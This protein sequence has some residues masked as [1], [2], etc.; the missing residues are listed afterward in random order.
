MLT[1]SDHLAEDRLLWEFWLNHGTDAVALRAR[2]EELPADA[3]GAYLVG[4]A[5]YGG[6]EGALA[7]LLERE[8][9]RLPAG[10]RLPEEVGFFLEG[11]PAA[12]PASPEGRFLVLLAQ[13]PAPGTARFEE[14]KTAA[15]R[16]SSWRGFARAACRANLIPAVA[17]A[18]AQPP[19]AEAVPAAER[20]ALA[21]AA[22]GIEARNRRMLARLASLLEAFAEAGLSPVLLKETAL[23]LDVYPG[24][25][26]RMI[27]DMD[28]LFSASEIDRAEEILL[29]R[30]YRSF[31]GIWSRAW[32]REHHHHIAPL[33]SSEEGI[34]IEPHL[35]IWIPR[36]SSKSIIP[37]MIAAAK[38]HPR[39]RAL[40]PAP[41]H[42]LF[43]LLV[44]IHGNV[45]IGKLGQLADIVALLAA[46][47]PGIDTTR[48][49]DFARRTGALPFVRDSLALLSKACGP[50]YLSE[51]APGL[52]TILA[53]RK[54][55]LDRKLLHAL[56]FSNLCGFEPRGR[57]LSVAGVRLLHK[58]LILPGGHAARISF[59]LKA[60]LG[61][62]KDE[63]GTGHV[64]RRAEGSRAQQIA[65]IL[66]FPFRAAAR[67]LR[68]RSG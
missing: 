25:G 9:E 48:V 7:K 20:E 40:A 14:A 52:A 31:E 3:N 33:V 59:F 1:P 63:E 39:L 47:G 51:R 61:M 17:S 35:G 64:T 62:E 29:A 43:H 27:G 28:I 44:D 19:L 30:G 21:R 26:D 60:L 46:K 68:R 45:S 2:L 34:K 57:A 42:V 15:R 53:E 22:A 41:E 6:F 36:S 49:A 12:G 23:L 11:D 24:E 16:V 4:N 67:V 13:R 55:T 5:L 10:S 56:A 65:R 37:E 58:T 38:P 54:P 50:G 66:T 32:Y 18:L 8:R